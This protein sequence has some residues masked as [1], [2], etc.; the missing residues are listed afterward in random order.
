MSGVRRRRQE[1]AEEEEEGGEGGGGGSRSPRARE[2]YLINRQ[3]LK[4]VK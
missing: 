2:V 3:V 1:E 4:E